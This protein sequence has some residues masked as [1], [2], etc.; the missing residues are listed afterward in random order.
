MDN[1]W[2]DP[3]QLFELRDAVRARKKT[4]TLDGKSFNIKYN[5]DTFFIAP[6]YGWVPCGH[7]EYAHAFDEI[8]GL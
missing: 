8:G 3:I 1:D 5:K 7:F 6:K 2:P 4:I